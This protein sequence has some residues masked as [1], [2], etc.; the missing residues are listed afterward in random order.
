LRSKDA[1]HAYRVKA[2][3]GKGLLQGR[4]VVTA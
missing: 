1:V 4:H 2:E 3:L